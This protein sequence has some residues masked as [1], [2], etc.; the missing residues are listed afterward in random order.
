VLSIALMSPI[1]ILKLKSLKVC[2]G[3][4]NPF[5]NTG[6]PRYAQFW[7]SADHKI[8]LYHLTRKNLCTYLFTCLDVKLLIDQFHQNFASSFF[9]RKFFC[10]FYVLALWLCYFS[11]INNWLKSCTYNI[12]QIDSRSRSY[13]TAF[14]R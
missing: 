1:K 5:Q 2:I 4:L 6:Y 7:L 8:A 10:S 12:D 9:V 13:K 3:F 14:L 11:V